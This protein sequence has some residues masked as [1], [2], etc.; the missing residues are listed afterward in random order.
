M[1]TKNKVKTVLEFQD[2]TKIQ[3]QL[4]LGQKNTWKNVKIFEK[5]ARTSLQ[6]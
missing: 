2:E 1:K 6:I 4:I 3:E 5:Q